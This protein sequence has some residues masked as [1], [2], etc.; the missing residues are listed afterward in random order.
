MSRS[1]TSAP[2]RDSPDLKVRSQTRPVIRLR[3]LTRLNA[4]PLPGFTNSFSTIEQGSPSSI[5]FRPP[6]NSLVEQ[7]AIFP[8]PYSS[9]PPEPDGA[10]GND[11]RR[12]V[13]S[14]ARLARIDWCAA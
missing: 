12:G 6:L 14:R 11:I 8:H 7:F 2:S 1:I 10:L 3:S 4:W 5:T 13:L 9:A